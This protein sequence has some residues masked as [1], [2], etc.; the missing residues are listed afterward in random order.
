M[1]SILHLFIQVSVREKQFLPLKL[2]Y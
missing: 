2:N 1:N